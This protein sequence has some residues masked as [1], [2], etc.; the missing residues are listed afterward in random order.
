MRDPFFIRFIGSIARWILNG[1]NVLYGWIY[2][3]KL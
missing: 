2:Y 1:L 3:T